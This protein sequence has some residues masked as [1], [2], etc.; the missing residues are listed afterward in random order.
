MNI[1]VGYELIYQFPQPT[2][3]LLMLNVHYS[4]AGDILVADT[5][6]ISPDVPISAYRDGFGNWCSRLVAPAG[7]VRIAGAGTVD[8]SGLP[9]PVAP[10]ALQHEVQDLPDDTLLY[11]L[12]SRYC[13]TDALTET[14]WA[15][16]GNTAAR[17]GAG[18]GGVRFCAP[19]YHLRL[20]AGAADPH[21]VA[22]VSGTQSACAGI[23]RIWRWRSA[24]A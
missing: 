3:M 19:A 8:D 13:E 15:L 14:A 6:T 9:D 16:F 22:G 24:G 4:R 7:Q 20:P 12:G 17:L 21:G 1:A 5:M 2:P 11:L 10:D 18:A 23:M